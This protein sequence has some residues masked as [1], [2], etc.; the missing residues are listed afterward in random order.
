MYVWG[1]LALVGSNFLGNSLGEVWVVMSRFEWKIE[2]AACGSRRRLSRESGVGAAQPPPRRHRPTILVRCGEFD[3]E[4]AQGSSLTREERA[5]RLLLLQENG[6][7]ATAMLHPARDQTH[8]ARAT[9]ASPATE[10]NLRSRPQDRAQHGLLAT[11]HDG[12]PDR[13]QR[14]RVRSDVARAAASTHLVSGH[15]LCVDT[16]ERLVQFL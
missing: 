9:A 5:V 15:D 3:R 14:D 2:S 6:G 8:L 13:A 4:I 12:I 11:T 10:D 1:S 16:Q 7:R